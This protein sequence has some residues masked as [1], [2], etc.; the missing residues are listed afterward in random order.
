VLTTYRNT[1]CQLSVKENLPAKHTQI[2]ANIHTK[3][4]VMLYSQEAPFPFSDSLTK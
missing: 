3:L 2:I 1:E 4:S